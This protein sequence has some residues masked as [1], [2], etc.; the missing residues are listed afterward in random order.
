MR[1]WR[2]G[3]W[4]SIPSSSGR[5][6]EKYSP[7]KLPLSIQNFDDSTLEAAV[8]DHWNN[9]TKPPGS[10]GR[11][12]ELVTRYALIRGERLPRLASK[13][14]YIFCGDHGVTAEGV[15]AFPS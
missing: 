11:L 12:E 1:R 14:M 3:F 5:N 15:S 9:L 8:Q 13:G 2:R 7:V 6:M 4:A 10:L